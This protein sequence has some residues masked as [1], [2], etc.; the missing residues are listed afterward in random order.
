MVVVGEWV[1]VVVNGGGGLGL[2]CGVCLGFYSGSSGFG[3]IWVFWFWVF[4]GCELIW[5]FSG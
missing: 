4:S 5:V 2:F 1:A 3:L